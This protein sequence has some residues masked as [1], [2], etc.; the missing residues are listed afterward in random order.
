MAK[1]R[2]DGC[3]WFRGYRRVQNV[4]GFTEARRMCGFWGLL[5]LVDEEELQAGCFFRKTERQGV[6]VQVAA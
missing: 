3:S 4:E 6:Q 5:S 2:C 1:R